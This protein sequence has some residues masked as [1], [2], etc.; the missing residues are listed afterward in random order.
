MTVIDAV[1]APL[2]QRYD[3]ALDAVSVTLPPWQNVVGRPAVI[4]AAGAALTVTAVGD[5]VPLQPFASV[6]ATL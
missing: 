5:D 2:D 3:A 1:V 4:V 6:T